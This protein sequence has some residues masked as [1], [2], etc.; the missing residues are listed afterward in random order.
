MKLFSIANSSGSLGAVVSAMGCAGCFPALGAFGSAIG[1][2]FLSGSEGLFINTLMPLFVVIALAA[3]LMGWI[4]HGVHSR[5]LLSMIGP[6]AV[7]LA[8]YPF[9]PYA[10]STWL[11]YAGIISMLAISVFD[12]LK[13][14]RAQQCQR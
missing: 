6:L 10:W 12:I 4:Q 5:G 9:W 14:P 3:S 11:F 8:L 1:L 2:G 7:L 13:P